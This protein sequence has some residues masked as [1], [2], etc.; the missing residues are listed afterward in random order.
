[1]HTHIHSSATHEKFA[2]LLDFSAAAFQIWNKF[3]LAAA[4][5]MYFPDF[6]GELPH[7]VNNNLIPSRL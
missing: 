3:V 4:L 5:F 1:M 2:N 7:F 6:H